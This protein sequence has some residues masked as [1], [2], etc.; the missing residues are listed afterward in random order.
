MPPGIGEGLPETSQGGEEAGDEDSTTATEKIVEGYGQ[1]ASDESTTKI[2]SRVDESQKP[3]RALVF[4]S[5]TELRCI[6]KLTAVN[7]SL[8]CAVS[9]AIFRHQRQQEELY[10]LPIPCTAAHVEQSTITRYR[11]LG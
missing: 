9:S 4:A 10:H 5:N 8:V 1:P 2:R 6:E 3:S 7:D 11:S